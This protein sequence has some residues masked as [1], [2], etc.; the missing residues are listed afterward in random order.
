MGYNSNIWY[1]VDGSFNKS[2]HALL[3]YTLPPPKH[4]IKEKFLKVVLDRVEKCKDF[5]DN[6]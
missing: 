3:E 4:V 2:I 5:K 6:L 1:L